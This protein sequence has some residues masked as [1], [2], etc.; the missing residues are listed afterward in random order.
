MHTCIYIHVYIYANLSVCAGQ[1]PAR[2]PLL[3][4]IRFGGSSEQ[5]CVYIYTYAYVRI[6]EGVYIYMCVSQG[7]TH[8]L[9]SV[10][11]QR[12]TFESHSRVSHTLIQGREKLQVRRSQK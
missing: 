1:G 4:E 10:S 11:F 9:E 2:E 3:E 8:A 5:V 12:E 6:F 7:S